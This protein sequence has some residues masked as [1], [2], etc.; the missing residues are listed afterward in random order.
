MWAEEGRENVRVGVGADVSEF[1]S[2]SGG[3]VASECV[4]HWRCAMFLDASSRYW[5][6]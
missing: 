2:V 4:V 6:E 1:I 3:A 5:Q